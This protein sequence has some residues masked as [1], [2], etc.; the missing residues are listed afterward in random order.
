MDIFTSGKK[1]LKEGYSRNRTISPAVNR[2]LDFGRGYGAGFG[3]LGAKQYGRMRT[4][5]AESV[6]SVDSFYTDSSGCTDGYTDG[7]LD[8][9]SDGTSFGDEDWS[10]EESEDGISI[11]SR[12]VQPRDVAALRRNL[13]NK[14][15]GRN[16]YFNRRSTFDENLP[17]RR[18][19][20]VEDPYGYRKELQ[21]RR[22][23][24]TPDRYR[25][26][27]TS[28]KPKKPSYLTRPDQKHLYGYPQ[29]QPSSSPAADESPSKPI[30][31]KELNLQKEYRSYLSPVRLSTSPSYAQA[32]RNY[33]PTKTQ[34]APSTKSY[35]GHKKPK[36][37]LTTASASYNAANCIYQRLSDSNFALPGPKGFAEFMRASKQDFAKAKRLERAV[38]GQ[39]CLTGPV[40]LPRNFRHKPTLLLDMDET[41]I[42]SEEFKGHR[43]YDI[44]V[45]MG[46]SGQPKAKIGVF[47]RP[48]CKEFLR[49]M[50]QKY[51]LVIF[52]AA[53]QDYADKVLDQ[54]DPLNDLFSFRLYRQHCTQVT[55]TYVKDFRVV[56]NRNP[57]EMILVDNLIYSYAAN[58]K[59]G[60]PIKP[61]IDEKDDCELCFLANKLD[62]IKSYME[63]ADFLE[64]CFRFSDFYN[65]L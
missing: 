45:E 50:R 2:R 57:S 46:G 36:L 53:R 8:D 63:V 49:R 23:G 58:M 27:K 17:S 54:L 26:Y 55:G 34:N 6:G 24:G 9:L 37:G 44:V 60:I 40:Y 30:S 62:G 28:P 48:Y 64:S 42:H 1:Q 59:N 5:V 4:S 32:A 22:L 31:N 12:K 61:F 18:S 41:L 21:K 10:D 29:P 38:Q 47:V 3:T 25:S 14:Y 35:L 33:S 7:S 15:E 65:S 43:K 39:P 19:R 20:G 51:E 56:K 52:T 13:V 11:F 16:T